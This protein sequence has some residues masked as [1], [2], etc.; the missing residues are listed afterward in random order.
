[1]RRLSK[2]INRNQIYLLMRKVKMKIIIMIICMLLISQAGHCFDGRKWNI[3]TGNIS[4]SFIRCSPIGAASTLGYLEPP[5]AEGVLAEFKKQGIVSFEDYVA[6]GAVERDPGKWDWTQ[7]D[8]V[9]AAVKKAGLDYVAYTWVHFP[10]LWLRDSK[11]ATLMRCVEHRQNTNYLSI[12]DPKT[13]EHYDH[14][15]KALAEHFGDKIDGVY[16][17]ILGPYGEGNYPLHVPEFIN[18]GHCHEGYW[19]EDPYALTAFRDAMREKYKDSI[20]TLNI[21]WGTEHGSFSDVLPPREISEG[22][23][24]SL[25]LFTTGQDRRR[26]LDFISW[27]HQAIIDFTEESI[28]VTLKYFPREKVRTKP[29]GN[30]GNQNPIAWGTYCPGYAKMAAQYGIVLQPADCQGAYFADKWLGTA[31]NFYG[32]KL[33]TEPAGGLDKLSFV[34]RMFSDASCGASELFTYEFELHVSEI[35]KYIHLYTGRPSDTSVVIFCP[36]TLH[37]LGGDVGPTIRAAMN[38]RDIADYDV[39][40]ELPIKDGAL[41]DRYRLMVMYQGDFVEQ[42]VLDHIEGWVKQGGALIVIGSKPFKN[43]EGELWP[44]A[45]ASKLAVSYTHLTLPTILLV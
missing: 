22:Q 2:L 18:M 1:M 33:S 7:H 44:V 36:T 9:Y 11:D 26:W 41:T 27:Y 8:N 43:V 34:R 4:V 38:L 40:D 31:Y 39:L 10:P 32:V 29:G 5:P 13:I 15:Y 23:T 28:K 45:Q 25:E 6:W 19:C 17:C 35:Q 14:F 42:T 12:F 30:H 20:A 21:A 16:A 24:I 37:N 3:S